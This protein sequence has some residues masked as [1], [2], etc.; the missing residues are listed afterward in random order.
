MQ[1][2]S[3]LKTKIT[4]AFV[5]LVTALLLVI[6]IYPSAVVRRQLINVKEKEMLQSAGV[7]SYALA[8]F[9]SLTE[10]NIKTAL[11][12]LDLMGERLVM[13]VNINGGV[14]YDSMH[15][16]QTGGADA[17]TPEVKAA[18]AG[19]DVFR[20]TYNESAFISRAACPVIKDGRVLGAVYFYDHDTDSADLINEMSS[21]LM[22]VSAG[23]TA[24]SA[25]FIAAVMIMMG[26]R[27]NILLRGVR[28][29]GTGNYAYRISMSGSDELA[30]VADEFNTL[31]GRLHSTEQLRRQFVS[32]ASHELKTPLASIKLLSDSILQTENMSSDYLREFLHDIGDEIDRL[33]RITEG[34]LDL[35]K[36]D[37]LPPVELVK[38]DLQ[39]TVRKAAELLK[40]TAATADVTI[41]LQI[42]DD[43]YVM[44]NA[45][46]LHQVLFNL[47]ENA[48]K[49]NKPGGDVWVSLFR[50]EEWTVLQVRD[51]GVGIPRED[52]K[53][54]FERFYR[55]DKA[56]SRATGGTGLG[57]SIVKEWVENMGGHIEVSS[58]YGEGSVFR[59]LLKSCL[60]TL[61]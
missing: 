40:I 39:A 12:V 22:K 10:D 3:S 11:T 46:G 50:R 60:E 7:L 26:R 36:F 38:C 14:I 23:V 34:L 30:V 42:P 9:S 61:T 8:G 32:D 2:F 35:N 31:S 49:Y 18:F 16:L 27:F 33:T 55:V 57:L 47:M 25:L 15:G 28:E 53:R 19:K 54:I 6:N 5:L 13:V 20:C 4:A 45:D 56:R 21:N 59:I 58:V 1:K 43:F 37:S 17:E 29:V 48:V 41:H 44:G 24:F 51:S 52:I